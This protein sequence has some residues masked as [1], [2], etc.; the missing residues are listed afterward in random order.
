LAVIGL[1]AA[2]TAIAGAVDWVIGVTV[3]ALLAI[4]IPPVR[5]RALSWPADW[6]ASATAAL[7]IVAGGGMGAGIGTLTSGGGTTIKS[8]KA[9]LNATGY[10]HGQWIEQEGEVGA[11]AFGEPGIEATKSGQHLP[12]LAFVRVSCRVYVSGVASAHPD[13]YWYRIVSKP[14]NDKYL[15]AANTFWNGSN[16][17]RG[18]GVKNTDFHVP[19]CK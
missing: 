9:D 14:W 19:L 15:A 3:G 7:I 13:G 5:Q 17:I 6:R 2:A 8:N 18:P 10:I 1:I 11:E 16:V 4:A 12:P